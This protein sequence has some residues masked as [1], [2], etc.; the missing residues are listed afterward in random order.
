MMSGLI[1]VRRA[2]MRLEVLALASLREQVPEH[3]LMYCKLC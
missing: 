3:Q 2:G 1:R